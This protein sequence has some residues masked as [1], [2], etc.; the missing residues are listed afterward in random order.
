MIRFDERE[1]RQAAADLT[2]VTR[3]TAGQVYAAMGESATDL[4]DTWRRNAKETAGAHGKHYPK[5]IV[6]HPRLSTN[7]VF[8]IGPDPRLP[9]GG[10]SFEYGSSK[11]PAHLDGQ[12]AMDEVQ[13]RMEKRVSDALAG[14]FEAMATGKGLREYVTKSGKTRMATD[15]QIANWTRGAA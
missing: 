9:Q 6:I 10:M 5:S 13:P 4:R 11:Q 8:D 2:G 12:R 14:A 15:A 3:A 7:I 1:L